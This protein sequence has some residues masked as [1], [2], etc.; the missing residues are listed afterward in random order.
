MRKAFFRAAPVLL[1]PASFLLFY[2]RGGATDYVVMIIFLACLGFVLW[3]TRMKQKK[4]W[5]TYELVIT[6]SGISRTQYGF[7]DISILK[8]DVVEAVQRVDGSISI[9]AKSRVNNIAIPFAVENRDQLI[10][11]IASF[12]TIRQLNSDG[13]WRFYGGIT[14]F[15]VLLVVCLVSSNRYVTTISGILI[16]A[17][18]GYS[19]YETSRSKNIESRT[20]RLAFMAIIPILVLI[21]W[22]ISRW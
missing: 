9:I 22:I 18:L 21:Y 11:E 3:T 8:S 17:L 6:Q 15:I 19:I 13:I 10:A 1:I 5:Q 7:P 14:V 12:T 2:L 20:K 16:V 4:V